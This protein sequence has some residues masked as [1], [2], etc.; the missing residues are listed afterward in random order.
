MRMQVKA[1]LLLLFVAVVVV[2][3]GGVVGTEAKQQGVQGKEGDAGSSLFRGV[4]HGAEGFVC[5]TL[6]GESCSPRLKNLHGGEVRK[7]GKGVDEGL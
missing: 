5:L 7:V 3:A 2:V 4:G 1:Q 6:G